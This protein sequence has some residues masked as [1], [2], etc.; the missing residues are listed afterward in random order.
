MNGKKKKKSECMNELLLYVGASIIVGLTGYLKNYIKTKEVFNFFRFGT[1]I[2][3][4]SSA[5]F[6]IFSFF[7]N[8]NIFSTLLSIYGLTNLTNIAA[9]ICVSIFEKNKK[10]ME[11]YR[12]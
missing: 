8:I 6:V 7:S 3:V 10:R 5:G 9:N 11:G 4:G 2:L 1:T 12:C